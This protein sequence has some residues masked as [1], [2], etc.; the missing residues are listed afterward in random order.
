MKAQ[1]SL[2]PEGGNLQMVCLI[3]LELKN[4][5]M[6]DVQGNAQWTMEWMI[7]VAGSNTQDAGCITELQGI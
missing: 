6:I 3:G 1:Q 4:N 5:D 2:S 7:M